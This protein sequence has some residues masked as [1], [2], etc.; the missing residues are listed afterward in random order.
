MTFNTLEHGNIAQVNR[1]LERFVGLVARF[2][3]A[4][5]EAAEVDRMLNG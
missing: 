5:S 4:V 1:V 2:A 3:F